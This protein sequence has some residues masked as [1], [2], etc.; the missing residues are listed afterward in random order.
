VCTNPLNPGDTVSISALEQLIRPKDSPILFPNPVV[1]HIHFQKLT[2]ESQVSIYSTK[3]EKLLEENIEPLEQMDVS[4]LPKGL[5]L[6]HIEMG[7]RV[8]TGKFLKE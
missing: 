8:F 7:V 3:G 2:K 4:S 1:D 5:Y 6:Y